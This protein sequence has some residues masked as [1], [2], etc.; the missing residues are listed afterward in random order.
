MLLGHYTGTSVSCQYITLLPWHLYR[1]I[2]LLPI[3]YFVT[4]TGYHSHIWH[5]VLWY[6]NCGTSVLHIR[7]L[8]LSRPTVGSL[9]HR[10][11][12]QGIVYCLEGRNGAFNGKMSNVSKKLFVWENR[13]G[14]GRLFVWQ[15]YVSRQGSCESGCPAKILCLQDF[16]ISHTPP[17][18]TPTNYN[19]NDQ[20]FDI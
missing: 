5:I 10:R 11:S 9:D 15:V 13:Q 19:H 17:P 6:T 14:A 1:D 4:D 16:P 3:L 12:L 7:D 18:Q 8:I 20:R 2:T